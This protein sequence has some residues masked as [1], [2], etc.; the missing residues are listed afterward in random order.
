MQDKGL[1]RLKG[2]QKQDVVMGDLELCH[3]KMHAKIKRGTSV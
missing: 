1:L 2:L 3:M